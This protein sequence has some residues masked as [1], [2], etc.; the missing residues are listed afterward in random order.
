VKANGRALDCKHAARADRVSAGVGQA[1]PDR[2]IK[3]GW[4]HLS[5]P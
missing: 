4:W 3:D 1:N 5:K 2:Q